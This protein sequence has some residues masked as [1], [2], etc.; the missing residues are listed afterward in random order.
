METALKDGT[1][2]SRDTAGS[3]TAR[4]E[5]AGTANSAE[6][7]S[8]IEQFQKELDQ[9]AIDGATVKLEGQLDKEFVNWL[10]GTEVGSSGAAGNVQVL[11]TL[12]LPSG[13]KYTFTLHRAESGKDLEFTNNYGAF[14]SEDK[15]IVKALSC[16]SKRS[17]GEILSHESPAETTWLKLKELTAAEQINRSNRATPP[18]NTQAENT[19][20]KP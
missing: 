2:L 14:T 20:R 16:A 8:T 1:V 19:S 5:Y 17:L 7:K 3:T 10:N 13:Q 9:R 11:Y 15:S 18:V 4:A 6:I 12:D